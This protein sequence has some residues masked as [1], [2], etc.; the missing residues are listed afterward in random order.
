MKPLFS[1]CLALCGAYLVI[2]FI[3]TY[4]DSTHFFSAFLGDQGDGLQNFWNIWWIRFAF[5]HLRTGIYQTGYIYYPTGTSLLGLTI[6]LTNTIPAAFLSLATGIALAYNLMLLAGFVLGG[7]FTGLLFRQFGS[8]TL[9]AFVAGCFYTFSEY[10]FAHATGHFQLIAVEWIPLFLWTWLRLL[11]RPSL[12]RAL[13]AA[14][15][16]LLVFF[17]DYYY[18]IFVTL[19][20]AI[21]LVFRAK[22]QFWPYFAVFAVVVAL[23][24]VPLA[25]RTAQFL[26]SPVSGRHDPFEFGADLLSPFVPGAFWRWNVL[27]RAVWSKFTA[28]A[29]EGCGYLAWSA[30][31]LATA[32]FTGK[33]HGRWVLLFIAG[34]FLLLSFG[35]EMRIAGAPIRGIWGPYH[36]FERIFPF[37]SFGGVPSRMG[38]MSVLAVSLLAGLGIERLQDTKRHWL[39]AVALAVAF[40]ELQ[41]SGLPVTPTPRP[42]FFDAMR[43]LPPGPVLD[44]ASGFLP[45]TL[46]YF[47]TIHEM[48]SSSGTVSRFPLAVETQEIQIAAAARQGNWQHLCRDLGFRYLLLNDKNPSP[49]SP[50]LEGDGY[51]LFDL[52]SRQS[53]PSR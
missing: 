8:S 11:D 45:N 15:G 7:C 37:I 51:R 46:R 50:I 25:L 3:F 14:V 34:L 31:L 18:A 10:H 2:F 27:T 40:L 35:P 29:V 30:L 24:A 5:F 17:T 42:H 41:P 36:H 53:D 32:A 28:P 19:A 22:R 12:F 48:P 43:A 16:F 26:Q 20:A 21:F 4:P 44:S 47:Q 13:S 49:L 1:R 33:K 6:S 9:G 39:I 52:C 38:L 23:I